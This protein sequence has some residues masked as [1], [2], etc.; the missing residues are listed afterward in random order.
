[1]NYGN[2]FAAQWARQRRACSKAHFDTYFRFSVGDEALPKDELDELIERAADR[3]FIRSAF[4]DA[5]KVTRS[6]GTTRATLHIR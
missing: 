5:L 1:M 6:D 3:E 4:R 2:D